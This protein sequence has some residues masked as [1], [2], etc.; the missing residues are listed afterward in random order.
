LRAGAE[1]R[2]GGLCAGHACVV[3]PQEKKGCSGTPAGHFKAGLYRAR[4]IH[5]GTYGT[6]IECGHA[7]DEARVRLGAGFRWIAVR[8][9]NGKGVPSVGADGLPLHKHQFVLG[10]DCGN[11][12]DGHKLNCYWRIAERCGWDGP[13]PLGARQGLA[14]F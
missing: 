5:V 3:I 4:A 10:D 14:G 8:K 6:A 12:H 7:V 11:K 1:R 13:A 9:M 2:E